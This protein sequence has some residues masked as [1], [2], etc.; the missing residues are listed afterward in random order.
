MIRAFALPV[1]FA[2]A[3]RIVGGGP[4]PPSQDATVLLRIGAGSTCTGSLVASNLVLTARHCIEMDEP[5]E[6]AVGSFAHDAA[7]VAS[8]TKVYLPETESEGDDIAI[9]A[10]DRRILD[11]APAVVRTT[12]PEIGERGI[13]VGYGEDGDGA[14]PRVRKQRASIR[15]DALGPAT[16]E[17]RTSDGEPI[18]VAL[19][20]KMI[21]TGESTCFGDSGGPLFDEEGAI[22]GITSAGVD[23]QCRDR[24]SLFVGTYAFEA[25][26]T[27]ARA[28]TTPGR[29]I[30]EGALGAGEIAPAEP[31]AGGCSTS[32]KGEAASAAVAF[33][34]AALLAA[35]R[36]RR[37][38]AIALLLSACKPS[39]KI[40]EP[41]VR[42][43]N[44]RSADLPAAPCSGERTEDACLA[45][46][47]ARSPEA[48]RRY[49]ESF[50]TCACSAPGACRAECSAAYCAG[51]EASAECKE[52]LEDAEACDDVA[53]ASCWDDA[54][55]RPL[56]DCASES[57]CASKDEDD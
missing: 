6:I 34:V 12:K 3:P 45:C 33:V 56:L 21:A 17:Y 7:P 32:P 13:A 55:C 5:I 19:A 48:V 51:L 40:G 22:I 47:Q 18:H 49:V 8:G 14:V 10:L 26:L 23:K 46:C 38:A 29:G 44:T 27:R 53:R 25:L 2:L 36:R 1:V 31:E 42:P 20:D 35:A 11:I 50:A 57:K 30:A 37:A 4:S 28:E 41:I 9:V 24:P 39:P 15:I 52:C 43:S 16:V 54:T